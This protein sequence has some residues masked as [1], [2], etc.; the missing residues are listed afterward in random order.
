MGSSLISRGISAGSAHDTTFLIQF[1]TNPAVDP[2][3][4]GQGE[5]AFGSTE[6]TTNGAG[7]ATINLLLASSYPQGAILSAT[8]TQETAPAAQGGT[9]GDTSEFSG[10]ISESSA[11]QFTQATYITTESSVTALITVSRSIATAQ[12]FVTYATAGGTADPGTDYVPI[13]PTTLNFAAGVSTETFTVMILD[14]HIVGGFKTVNL[15]LSS[16]YTAGNV[17][18]F[19]TTAVLQINDN[20]SGTS[21]QFLVTNT[22]DLGTGSLRQA[23]I[24]ADAVTYPSTILFD[25]PAAT[26]PLLAI[27][28]GNFDPSTQTWT[29]NLQSSL[30]TINRTVT[31]DGYSEAL[32]GIPFRYPSQI[33]SA[34][35]TV[36]ITGIVTG[37][38]FTLS[39]NGLPL[40]QGTTAPIAYNATPAQ[41]EAALDN[42]T[43]LAGNVAVTGSPGF[44]TVAFQGLLAGQQIPNL[45][46]NRGGLVGVNP[47]V[48]VGTLV[49]GGSALSDPTMITSVPNTT[50]A[51][52]GNNAKVRVIVNG[53]QIQSLSPT[54]GFAIDAS[55]CRVDGLIIEGFSGAGISVPAPT[56]VGN[57]IEGNFIGAYLVYPVDPSSGIPLVGLAS[58]Q[59]VDMGNSQQGI[60]V[61]GQNTTIGG[62]N[63]QEN[64][65]IAGNLQQGIWINT[66]GT[67]NV[68]EGNQIGMIGPSTTGLYFQVGNGADGVLV[69]GPSNI[70]GGSGD[71]AGNVISGNG[72]DGV[73]VDGPVA[74]ETVIGANVIGLG[75]GGGFV[76]GSGDPGNGGDGVLINDS[77]GNVIGGPGS[78]WG[79]TISSNAS[80]GVLITGATST[81][82]SVLNNLIGLTSGGNAKK[83]NLSYGV[84]DYSPQNT[85]GPGNVISGNLG[86]VLISGSQA[87]DYADAVVVEGNL[88]GTDSTGAYDLGNT[89]QGVLIQNATDAVIEGNGTGSQV[90]SGNNQGVVI[91]GSTATRDVVEGNLI[92]TDKTGLYAIPNAQ[93]GVAILGGTGN[94]IGGTTSAAQ[95]V[96]SANNWG[97]RIDGSSATDNLVAGNLIG[98]NITGKAALGNELNGVIFS[99]GASENTVGGTVTGAAN[100]IAFNQLAGV[101]VQSGIGDS[102]LSNSIYLNN[103]LGIVLAPPTPAPGPND[104]QAAPVLTSVVGGASIGSI[105][106]TLTSI[107]NTTFLIQ[108]FTSQVP[109]PSGH[110]QGQTYVGSA[111]VTT[112]GMGTATI[113]YSPS[114]LLAATAWVTAT[115]TNTETGD[116]SQFSNSESALPI[117]LE[118]LTATMSV[119][120]SAGTALVH[121]ERIGNLNAQV[122]VNYATSNGSAVA[123]QD[124]AAASGTLTFLPGEGDQTFSVIVLSNPSQAASSYTVNL[125]L[126][127]PTGGST[128]GS[129]STAVLTINNNAPPIL[130]FSSTTYTT[131]A[132]SNSA[133]VS[134]T[135]GGGSRSWTVQVQ[136]ATAGGSA[137]AGVDYTPVSGTLTFLANQTIATFTVPL[138]HGGVATVTKTVGLVLSGPTGGGQLGP[139]STATLTIQAG[140]S[141]YNPVGPTNPVPPQVTGEQLELGQA[142]ITAVLFS[143]SQPLNPSRVPDLGNYGYFVDVAGANGVFG[144][145]A[146]IYIPLS[147]AQY[148]PATFTVTVI[149]STPLPLNRFERITINGLANP[150]L[151]RGLTN[152]SGVLLSGLSNG[153]PGNPFVATFGL[154]SS[155]TYA[156]STGK[157][158]S[159]SLTGGGLI[160]MFRTPVG[161]AQTV[162]LEG[163]VPH[164][165]VLTLQANKAG[166]RTTY[167]PP[168]QGAAGVRFR[169]KPQAS[170][171]R[172]SLL[173]Q[174]VR[175]PH[176]KPAAVKRRK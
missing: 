63:P 170:A 44:Y 71:T 14:P 81:G 7:T 64:N 100:T 141:P 159:L 82:N 145:S 149:P 19:Q 108:F 83:G 77:A 95:N 109:D 9:P 111:T 176:V 173:P 10:D 6:V 136:Y 117:T 103:Q 21:G 22:N 148:N 118:Y 164:K 58:V 93:E 3:G 139:I 12:A 92:G 166:G 4:F 34:Q 84:T 2:S 29:I 36:T 144:T 127:N 67:A 175:T 128:L 65:V 43:G 46:G 26:D 113:S 1:F 27:P 140:S 79:N 69:E 80:A 18:D 172:R 163:A 171:F 60:Y 31:I 121:V 50:A 174:A 85:I 160:E 56:D 135:R 104:L 153:V 165:S 52:D 47:G 72:G 106:G 59:L 91:S 98:T 122:S 66:A 41:V 154:G 162:I 161:D 151:G 15:A 62:T 45:V 76:L 55:N 158:V 74:T 88:I 167:M 78:T 37:G 5:T 73:D 90:I 114:T 147:A 97:V 11:F 61:N 23:I 105:Q 125:T 86:G 54:T 75:P 168:I 35:Q 169:Y 116:T 101:L 115:A 32:T 51:V 24:N 49:E 129:P 142:G 138:L 133:I 39:T 150:L 155:L 33:T 30:P 137:V 17:I 131:Y 94:T 156:D 130:Q 132:G 89:Y 146:D 157:I 70:I 42:I 143:F 40:P 112:N 25:I 102:I 96:I 38:T 48:A 57:D 119:D 107:A 20:D 87:D 99:T 110:G 53:S 68:V 126:S 8:A 123:G 13:P 16:P 120:V 124:Y 134:V 28:A 152:T